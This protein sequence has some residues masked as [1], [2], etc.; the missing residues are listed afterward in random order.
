MDMRTLY[1]LYL[2]ALEKEPSVGEAVRADIT[3]YYERDP[4][5]DQYCL[6]LLYF[7][8]YHAIQAHASTT[9]CGRKGA[10]RW[11]ISCKTALPKCS[12]SISIRPPVSGRGL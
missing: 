2:H 7:K 12:A 8:G 9:A 11:P 10:K 4:A 6:P 3:A 1:E 5:C